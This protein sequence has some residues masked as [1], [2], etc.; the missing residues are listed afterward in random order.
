MRFRPF[1]EEVR[2][3]QWSS[4]IF[5][6]TPAARFLSD[7]ASPLGTQGRGHTHTHTQLHA[8]NLSLALALALARA[9]P[10]FLSLSLSSPSLPLSLHFS[11]YLPPSSGRPSCWCGKAVCRKFKGTGGKRCVCRGKKRG[12]IPNILA[13]LE[14]LGQ[15]VHSNCPAVL[16]AFCRSRAQHR[17]GGHAPAPGHAS[18]TARNL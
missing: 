10:L 17:G 9:L 2:P 3:R 15:G 6:R 7:R 13:H 18:V 11:S 1:R 12:I 5:S 8:R 16:C 4:E 14:S